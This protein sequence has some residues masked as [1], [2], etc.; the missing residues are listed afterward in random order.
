MLDLLLKT[1]RKRFSRKINFF[2][3]ELP[4][5]ERVIVGGGSELRSRYTGGLKPKDYITMEKKIFFH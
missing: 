3:N 1:Q 4:V 2:R 5:R